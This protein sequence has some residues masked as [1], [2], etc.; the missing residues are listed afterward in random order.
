LIASTKSSEV[1]SGLRKTEFVIWSTA[2]FIRIVV[3]LAIVLPK[4]NGANIITASVIK[5]A[6][7]ATWAGVFL[8]GYRLDDVDT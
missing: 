8:V 1:Q 2:N 5:R 3:V 7:P 4:T 6:K